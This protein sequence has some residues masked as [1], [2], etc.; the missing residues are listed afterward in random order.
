MAL[1]VVDA[2]VAPADNAENVVPLERG[3]ADRVL[4]ERVVA[5]RVLADTLGAAG[6][7][8]GLVLVLPE[9]AAAVPGSKISE[10]WGEKPEG[11]PSG[12]V[13]PPVR[14]EQ[15]AQK[16]PVQV[17]QKEDTA[18]DPQLGPDPELAPPEAAA[19]LAPDV[20]VEVL[21]RLSDALA[22]A[23][24]SSIGNRLPGWKRE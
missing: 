11:R 13:L 19:E 3:A 6:L 10:G 1:G 14:T 21:E 24:S 23:K 7:E 15:I 5:D 12:A 18:S 20:S 4:A 17:A 8:P 22:T 2:A 16:R 9:S